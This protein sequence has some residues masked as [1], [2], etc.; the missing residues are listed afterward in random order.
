MNLATSSPAPVKKLTMIQST[1][2]PHWLG[3]VARDRAQRRYC[4]VK[5]DAFT[6]NVW[7]DG[8][9]QVPVAGDGQNDASHAIHLAATPGPYN[10]V[11]G[12]R[13]FVIR[14]RNYYWYE[15]GMDICMM[16]DLSHQTVAHARWMGFQGRHEMIVNGAKINIF[17]LERDLEILFL[18]AVGVKV[19]GAYNAPAVSVTQE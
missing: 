5:V 11:T 7:V 3:V 8:F 9:W 10:P 1:I 16:T 15:N 13:R 12:Y 19:I 18:M 14:G 17:T 4:T 6:D 2:N